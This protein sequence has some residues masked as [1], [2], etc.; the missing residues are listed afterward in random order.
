M[1]E[2]KDKTIAI[3]LIISCCVLV[4]AIIAVLISNS[5]KNNNKSADIHKDSIVTE[6]AD[7]DISDETVA[8]DS[9]NDSGSD[10]VSDF[11]D[12][13]ADI[14]TDPSTA[15][16]DGTDSP[17]SEDSSSTGESSQTE[18]SDAA[19]DTTV[20]SDGMVTSENTD[21][22]EDPGAAANTN[23]SDLPEPTEVP[24]TPAPTKE[25][26][27]TS[28][29]AV[30]GPTATPR[31]T[32]TPMPEQK[33]YSPSDSVF[34]L[35]G[36]PTPTP[37][38]KTTEEGSVRIMGV[39]DILYHQRVIDSGLMSDGTRNYNFHYDYLRGYL[40]AAD[41]A[42]ANQETLIVPESYGYSG[43]PCFGTPKE[44]ADALVNAGFNVF[45]LA[46]NHVFDKMGVK[47]L[48]EAADYWKS[49]TDVLSTGIYG[50]VTDFNTLTIGEYNGIKIAFLNYTDIVNGYWSKEEL[51]SISGDVKLLRWALYH[52]EIKRAKQLADY[53]IVCPHWGVEYEL[54]PNSRQKE[55]A[56]DMADAGADLIIGTHPHVPQPLEILTAADGRKVPCYYSLGNCISNMWETG[57]CNLGIMADVTI[58]KTDSGIELTDVRAV[59]TVNFVH[60]GQTNYNVILLD[61]YTDDL[62]EQHA[63]YSSKAH[64]DWL[65][66]LYHELF[67]Y[68]YY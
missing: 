24:V 33:A 11:Y 60:S 59:P 48:L 19:T 2:N 63:S 57:A 35:S 5:Q 22:P 51:D 66:N 38:P 54:Q 47:G 27:P 46:T 25:P 42:I 6:T 3:S 29:P 13:T 34:T 23:S 61:D 53:V 40:N 26:E 62:G 36:H 43:Y 41:V 18:V 49:R 64:P 44:V 39:G 56:Q 15:T 28:A 16:L 20:A 21:M 8:S 68:D 1:K 32:A 58:K 7:T 52:D 17:A 55:I 4:I 67:G 31:P 12:I 50:N 37:L 9:Q 14:D 45:T 10:V 65:W 30:T